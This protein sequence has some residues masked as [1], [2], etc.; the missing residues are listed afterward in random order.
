MR[1]PARRPRRD[2]EETPSDYEPEAWPGHLC[3]TC[4]GPRPCRYHK[5]RAR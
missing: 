3:R 2:P 5:D 1:P 4:G